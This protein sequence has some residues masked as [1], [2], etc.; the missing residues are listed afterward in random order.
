MLFLK[1]FIF[2]VIICLGLL[3]M[4]VFNKLLQNLTLD[5]VLQT[6]KIILLFPVILF[7]I[8]LDK[9]NELWLSAVE[10]GNIVKFILAIFS[11]VVIF[12]YIKIIAIMLWWVVL[13]FISLFNK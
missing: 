11:C 2:V 10:T 7:F 12:Y 6:I 4:F 1:E 3:V 9:A 8:M 13:K 5:E